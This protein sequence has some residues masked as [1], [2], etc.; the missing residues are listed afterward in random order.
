MH[1]LYNYTKHLANCRNNAGMKVV[2]GEHHTGNLPS[3]GEDIGVDRIILV[4]F[5]LNIL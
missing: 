4:G 1:N 5:A 2:V 3:H